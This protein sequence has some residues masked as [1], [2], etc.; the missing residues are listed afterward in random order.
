M[1]HHVDGCE[2]DAPLSANNN[3]ITITMITSMP[4]ARHTRD[5]RPHRRGHT[6]NNGNGTEPCTSL[7]LR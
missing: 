4:E 5:L 6:H 1:V 3:A 7:A 2:I